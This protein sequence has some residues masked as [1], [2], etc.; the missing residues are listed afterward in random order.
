M[1]HLIGLQINYWRKFI[2]FKGAVFLTNF[3]E[4]SPPNVLTSRSTY[5]W[6]NDLKDLE[7]TKHFE[8]GVIEMPVRPYPLFLN[9]FTHLLNL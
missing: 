5:C 6:L 9:V 2:P 1:E 4:N 7:S 8:A 3:L